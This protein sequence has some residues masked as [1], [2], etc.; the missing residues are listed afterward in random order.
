MVSSPRGNGT[1]VSSSHMKPITLPDLGYDEFF[2]AERSGSE[3]REFPVARVISEHKGAYTVKNEEGEYLGA[4]TGKQIY[5]ASHREDFPAVGDWVFITPLPLGKAVIQG[6]LPR[7]TV[8][9]RKHTGSND[10]QIIAT[11]IDVAFVIESFDR[12]YNLNRFER[13]FAIAR[14]GGIQPAILLNKIDLVSQEEL[15][16]K[17]EEITERFGDV[18]V[19]PVSTV[20]DEG[21]S[22]LRAYLVKGKTYCFLGSSGVGKSSIINSLLG[23]D[24]IK[25]GEIGDRT[26]RGKHTTTSRMMYFLGSGGIVIDNPGV[27]EVG[28]T[29]TDKGVGDVFDEITALSLSCKFIDC[30]HTNE[31]GCAVLRAVE[32]GEVD[33]EKYRNFLRLKKEAEFFEMSELEKREKNRQFGKFIKKAK[34]ELKRRGH[35]DF[36]G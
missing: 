16:L 22:A 25:V 6:I 32:N 26:Q 24:R 31:P 17:L 33:E 28:M 2:A 3:L 5:D 21:L 11:N 9:K 15:H 27:R 23:E 34:D 35:K 19:I 7:R 12:D 36:G 30:A 20:S 1:M 18:P 13:Y 29:D 10:I 8:M 14:D 4:V